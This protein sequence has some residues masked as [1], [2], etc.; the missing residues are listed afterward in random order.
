MRYSA[1]DKFIWTDDFK[2]LTQEQLQIPGLHMLGYR[3]MRHCD[4]ELDLH[5]HHAME[6]IVTLKGKQHFVVENK[7]YTLY[8][9]D[10]FM[11]VPDEPHSGANFPQTVSEFVWFEFDLSSCKNFLGLPP[12]YS[13]FVYDQLIHYDSRIRKA[14]TKDLPL[15][16]DAFFFLASDDIQKQLLG[17]EHFVH[18]VV[19]NLCHVNNLG[20]LIYNDTSISEA[21]TYISAHLLE[22][23]NIDKI[24]EHVNLSPS[25][26]KAKFKEQVG[27]T[28]HAYITLLRIDTAKILLKNPDYSVTQVAY[29]LNFS[30]SNHFATVFKKHTGYTPT[31]F[32][33]CSFKGTL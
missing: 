26:F 32:K 19:N 24:A 29:L 9:G 7:L 3:D 33:N 23:L 18:F 16:K 2:L 11:T 4:E 20:N 30:S 5:Y 28:P 21:T 14:Y 6:F 15:L 27:I 22:D 10:I 8:G 17:Y 31:E 25:R 12:R 13:Q 1:A